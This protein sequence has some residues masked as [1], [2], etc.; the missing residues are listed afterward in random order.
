MYSVKND[1]V[2]LVYIYIHTY[3]QRREFREENDAKIYLGLVLDGLH[4]YRSIIN[5]K[6][7]NEGRQKE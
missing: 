4:G 2:W 3:I 7:Q 6:G 1:D 5:G